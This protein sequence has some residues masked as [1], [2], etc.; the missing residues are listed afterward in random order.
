M[1]Y[2][3]GP[4]LNLIYYNEELK[5]NYNLTKPIYLSENID[6][7][8]NFISIWQFL[9]EEHLII[10]LPKSCEERDMGLFLKKVDHEFSG[11]SSQITYPILTN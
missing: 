10:N 11:D 3:E 1:D 5:Y 7:I 8:L 6:E 9:E 4:E 2:S